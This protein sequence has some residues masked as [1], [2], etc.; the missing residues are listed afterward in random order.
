M[1]NILLQ[2]GTAYVQ[3]K[4]HALSNQFKKKK[5]YYFFEEMRNSSKATQGDEESL[6]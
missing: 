3:P 2:W 1:F 5:S 6:W 4:F